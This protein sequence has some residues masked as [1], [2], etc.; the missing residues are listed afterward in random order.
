[1]RW[2][3]PSLFNRKTG[4]LAKQ[5][6]PVFQTESWTAL[7]CDILGVMFVSFCYDS[8]RVKLN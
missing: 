3:Q 5:R 1:M 4:F 6:N 7:H 2:R 8:A